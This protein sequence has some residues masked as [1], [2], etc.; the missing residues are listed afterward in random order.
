MEN[1]TVKENTGKFGGLYSK[2]ESISYGQSFTHLVTAA[3]SIRAG[4]W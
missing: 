1:I 2:E 4:V 3:C